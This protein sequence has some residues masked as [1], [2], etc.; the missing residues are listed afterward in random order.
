MDKKE[1]A[2]ELF[3]LQDTGYAAMQVRIIPTVAAGN[4]SCFFAKDCI[5]KSILLSSLT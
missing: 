3:R 2:A 5:N 4:N 1:I